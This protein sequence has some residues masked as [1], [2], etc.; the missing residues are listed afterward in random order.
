VQGE[1][2]L[3]GMQIGKKKE[4]TEVPNTRSNDKSRQSG[5]GLGVGHQEMRAISRCC[6]VSA[7]PGGEQ[8]GNRRGRVE[9]GE[10]L[11]VPR[12]CRVHRHLKKKNLKEQKITV[13]KYAMGVTANKSCVEENSKRTTY[14][15]VRALCI[16]VGGGKEQLAPVS[17]VLRRKLLEVS[18]TVKEV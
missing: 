10:L 8:G 16:G 3:L 17:C 4:I 6:R 2:D 1:I 12:G 13:L 11:A 15:S 9:E 18:K 7:T 5:E 14:R